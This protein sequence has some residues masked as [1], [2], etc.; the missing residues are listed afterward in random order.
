MTTDVTYSL[1]QAADLTGFSLGK[2]RYNKDKLMAAGVV[3]TD[4]GWRIPHSVLTD[5]G[6]IGKKAPK[7]VVTLTPLQKAEARIAELEA[8]V[9]RLR[10]GNSRRGIFGG[11]KR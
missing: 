6:W 4:E 8:E 7:K 3:V 5:L 1:Q 9:A 2:F 10:D 11:R